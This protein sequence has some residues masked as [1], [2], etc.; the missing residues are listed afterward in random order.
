MDPNFLRI[1]IC[2]WFFTSKVTSQQNYTKNL[3][4][5]CDGT[6]KTGTIPDNLYTCNGKNKSCQGFLLFKS[7]PSYNSV[8]TISKLTHSDPSKLAHVNNVSL[9]ANFP[10]NKEVVVPVNCSCSGK[11]YQANSSFVIPTSQDTYFSIA[12][13][14][15]QG[16]SS[17]DSL[18]DENIYNF[19]SL[20]PGYELR[21]PLRCACPTSNQILNGTEYLLTYSVYWGDTVPKLSDRFNVSI[22]SILVGNGFS[23]REEDPTLFPFTT[24]LI[25][26]SAKPD[27]IKTKIQTLQMQSPNR[28]VL[29]DNTKGKSKRGFY[30]CMGVLAASTFLVISCI[31]VFVACLNHEKK[32]ENQ[33]P[34]LKKWILPKE[35][36]DGIADM[37][38]AFRIF[39]L[40]ELKM[41]TNNFSV[42]FRL[43]GSVYRGI[44]A[45]EEVA[46]KKMNTNVSKVVNI[47]HK[48]N[49]FNLIRLHGI[50][51]DEGYF[52]L[53]YKFMENGCL[54]DWLCNEKFSFTQSWSQR[55]QIALDIAKGLQYLHNFTNPASVHKDI[56]SRNILLDRNVRA[57]IANFG[58][59]RSTERGENGFVSM[60]LV[61][62]RGYMPPEYLDF[63]SVTTKM[64][65]YAF[66]VVMLELI[67]GKDVILM[68]DGR[69]TEYLSTAM[70]S[71]MAGEDLETKLGDFIDSNLRG[72]YG[73]ELALAITRLSMS[74]LNRDPTSRPSMNEVASALVNIQMG[75]MKFLLS[76]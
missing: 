55:I 39:S 49:H 40:D 61:G 54:K 41:A 72:N 73:L 19:T 35:V 12:N 36:V 67:T 33:T 58:L 26:F 38:Q 27:S 60:K 31:A 75:S 68:H 53:V 30:L 24:I 52:Y 28:Y 45:G 25:P 76:N 5:A 17:C 2:L 22:K 65:V 63:G 50:C 16:L 10:T 62:T 69:R 37:D 15:Y 29:N 21:V 42:E 13:N 44:L 46:I 74:C 51:E 6:D 59:A 64:D 14:T 57:K 48:M 23:E 43:K 8:L 47:L 34:N 66:G 9:S 32:K 20:L 1:F 18:I 56:N 4:L 71:V 3:V 11:Y 70:I 7:Q